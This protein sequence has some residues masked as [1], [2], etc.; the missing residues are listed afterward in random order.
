MAA[1]LEIKNVT[2]TFRGGVRAV[3][4]VTLAVEEGE[5]LTILGPSGCGQDHD[6]PHGGRVRVSRCGPHRARRARR[7]RPS[8]LPATGQHDVS[9]LRALP[10]S[11]GRAEHRLR[12]HHRRHEAARGGARGGGGAPHDRAARQGRPQAG[13]AFHRPEAARG[14]GACPD[15]AAED[16]AA[17]RA[18]VG[19]R[20][21]APRIDAGGVEAPARPDRPYFHDG[22]PRPDRGP[23]DVRPDRGDGC[24]PHR[25][26]GIADRPLR[27]A[28]R[29]PMSQTFW[30]PPTWSQAS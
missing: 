5:F 18:V 4:D 10:A 27:P 14:A 15:P 29:R 21:Q 17:R 2:K 28:P 11:H 16:P 8:A 25:A 24:R 9:G 22:N 23:G 12:P 3:D 30:A 26:G 7:D 6:A 1:I 19:A 13:G 20:R